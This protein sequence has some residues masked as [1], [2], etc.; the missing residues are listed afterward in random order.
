MAYETQ[1]TRLNNTN[2]LASQP[3]ISVNSDDIRID[4]DSSNLFDTGHLTIFCPSDA[5]QDRNFAF[6]AVNGNTQ[7]FSLNTLKR[8]M[9]R[10]KINWKK[11]DKEYY[12][13]RIIYR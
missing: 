10:A 7:A 13:E 1:L 9:Y 11:G 3:I 12:M 8:G 5:T 6:N 2:A 4:F